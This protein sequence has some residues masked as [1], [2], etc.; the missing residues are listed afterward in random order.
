[1]SYATEEE[2]NKKLN[3]TSSDVTYNQP[4]MLNFSAKL[5]TA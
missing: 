5:Q 3:K 2:L 4:W 1:M